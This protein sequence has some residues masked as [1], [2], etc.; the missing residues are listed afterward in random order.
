MY[1]FDIF[2]GVAWTI[3]AVF[4]VS[5]LVQLVGPGF[6][7]RAYERWDF[8]P[9]FYRVT[10]VVELVTAAF[11]LNPL[12]RE[13]GVTLAGLV[14]FVAVVTLL[15][16]RQYAYTLPGILLLLALIPASLAG[17]L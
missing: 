10:A 8:P 13:W 3:A 11:L 6:V 5:G 12:T 7:R 14:T 1:E 15:N 2:R 9:K 4:A 16:H 17:P